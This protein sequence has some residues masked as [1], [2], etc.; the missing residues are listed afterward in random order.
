MLSDEY[1][2]LHFTTECTIVGTKNRYPEDIGYR[3]LYK[4]RTTKDQ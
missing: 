1:D 2:T 3:T 4:D